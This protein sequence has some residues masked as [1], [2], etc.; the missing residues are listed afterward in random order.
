MKSKWN[1]LGTIAVLT[2]LGAAACGSTDNTTTS[3]TSGSASSTSTG[4]G[5]G[6]TG[7]TTGP[8]GSTTGPAG[9]STGRE[10][11]TTGPEGTTT[12]PAGTTTGPEGTTTGPTATGTTSG[13]TTT[14]GTTTGGT[15]G[16]IPHGPGNGGYCDGM[17]VEQ[18]SAT[19][20]LILYPGPA[21]QVSGTVCDPLNYGSDA[22]SFPQLGGIW[23]YYTTTSAQGVMPGG[24]DDLGLGNAPVGSGAITPP[25]G[26]MTVA[27]ALSLEAGLYDAGQ[28]FQPVSIYGVVT[29]SWS[30]Y[31]S[32][33]KGVAGTYYI[34]DMPPDGGTPQPN[35]GV[36][37]YVPA[38]VVLEAEDGGELPAESPERG[39][40]IYATNMSLTS[41]GN[42]LEFEF[43]GG[44]S[45][46]S[47][48]GQSAMP[49]AVSVSAADLESQSATISGYTGMRVVNPNV[50]TVS[51]TCPTIQ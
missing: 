20:F 51:D 38:K 31:V 45:N 29:F 16:G 39:D 11:T 8:A 4:A 1:K 37:V 46:L 35:S 25:D 21:D 48:L 14:G 17:A 10:G 32:K 5:A 22:G 41:Y 30:Y 33:G 42:N 24:C 43:V 44:S 6:T 3:G 23:A 50:S 27:E 47:V 36:E 34:Q 13:G 9:T 18:A 15:T 28:S 49:P 7:T 40:V 12:G 2:L 26:G 19:D